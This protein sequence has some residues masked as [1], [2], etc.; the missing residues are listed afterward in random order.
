MDLK[1]VEQ[2][3]YKGPRIPEVPKVQEPLSAGDRKGS[4]GETNTY[5][6]ERKLT[7]V[8]GRQTKTSVYKTNTLATE[9]T[10]KCICLGV[11]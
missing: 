5:W 11:Q 2:K 1:I 9:K 10:K 6:L 8:Y 3:P 4:W 7:R